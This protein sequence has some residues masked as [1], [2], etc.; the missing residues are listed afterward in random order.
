MSDYLGLTTEQEIREYMLDSKDNLDCS[1][2]NI[3][4]GFFKQSANRSYYCVFDAV[5]ACLVT[6]GINDHS[7]H[8]FVIG[9]FRQ[10]FVKTGIFGVDISDNLKNL[11]E[12]RTDSDYSK[13]F[14]VSADEA[15]DL[16]EKATAV[17][18]EIR[19]YINNYFLEEGLKT[20]NN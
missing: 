16:A 9:K 3:Q 13:G 19:I 2:F 5:C 8:G 12:Y 17:Y 7:N 10:N 11:F 14:R 1:L 15:T 6:V 18:E 20:L 4:G